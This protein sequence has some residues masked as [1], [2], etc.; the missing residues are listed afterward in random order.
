VLGLPETAS[1]PPRI[2]G[3]E[4]VQVFRAD[5]V[6]RPRWYASGDMIVISLVAGLGLLALGTVLGVAGAVTRL[7]RGH[8]GTLPAP[9]GRLTAAL[10]L[11]T[12]ATWVFFASYL[13]GVADL[14]LN[15]RHN[16]LLSQGGWLVAQL[17]GILAAALLVHVVESWWRGGRSDRSVGVLGRA[18]VGATVLGA[19]VL[20]VSAA[21]WGVY[22]AVL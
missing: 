2:A 13:L 14:A 16:P 18:V 21:Y 11:A 4:P 19:V 10:H 12:L 20:L 9:L 6:D 17:A 1:A 3:A 7:R 8:G 22:P 15:Y 5:P